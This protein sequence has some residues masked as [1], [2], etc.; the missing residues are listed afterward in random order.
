MPDCNAMRESMPML[1]T[2]SL[3]TAGRE[4]THLHIESCADC[5]DEWTALRETW[6]L[7]DELP[8][9]EPPAHLKA[10][11]LAD[12]SPAEKTSNV[13]PFQRRPAV[14]WEVHGASEVRAVVASL[15]SL[16]CRRNFR[17][18]PSRRLDSRD[19]TLGPV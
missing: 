16:A 13:V 4:A 3:D 10:R 12:V 9:V 11:F 19:A 18:T 15:G 8:R 2:E 1:L 14:K 7:L 5:S 6:Q 17:A